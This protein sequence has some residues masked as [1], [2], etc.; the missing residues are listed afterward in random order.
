[1]K[2]LDLLTI[3]THTLLAF[4]LGLAGAGCL[5]T[6]FDLDVSLWPILLFCALLS[7]LPAVLL[8]LRW[9]LPI[10]LGLLAAGGLCL[11]RTNVVAQILSLLKV[12]F[13]CYRNAYGWQLPAFL[14]NAMPISVTLAVALIAGTCTLMIALFLQ[15]R[16]AFGCL[17]FAALPL[18][19]C[20]VVTDTVP[21]ASWLMLL[22]LGCILVLLSQKLRRRDPRQASRLVALA[23]IPTLVLSLILFRLN[24]EEDYRL[25]TEEGSF[26]NQLLQWLDEIPMIDVDENGEVN[27]DLS[28]MPTFP[29]PTFVVDVPGTVPLPTITIT[30]DPTFSIP[31]G[32]V[33]DI[34]GQ[35]PL[36][37]TGP[38]N[39]S[40]KQ[41]MQLTTPYVYR[42]TLYLRDRSYDMYTGTSWK[43]SGLPQDLSIVKGYLDASKSLTIQTKS[44]YPHYYAPYYTH[45]G[46]YSLPQGYLDNPNQLKLYS[47]AFYPLCADWQDLWYSNSNQPI[48]AIDRH[49]DQTALPDETYDKA[50]RILETLG[51]HNQ[52]SVLEAAELIRNYVSHSATY[53][54]NTA[55]MPEEYE[56]FALWFLEESDTGYCVHFATAATVLLRAAGIPARYVEGYM[57]NVSSFATIVRENQAHAWVEY[58]LPE[59]GWVIMEATP[60]GEGSP[61]PPDSTDPTEPTE[62]TETTEP[63]EPT[64]PTD[65]TDPTETT[66]P[67]EPTEPTE[68]TRPSETTHP[69]KPTAPSATT[70]VP[71]TTGTPVPPEPVDRTQLWATLAV[72]LGSLFVI[73]AIIAQW[74]LRL[75]LTQWYL[76]RGSHNRRAL[77]LWQYCR[78]MAKL[79]RQNAPM[80]LRDLA[81]KAAYSPYT[82]TEEELQMFYQYTNRC[83]AHLQSRPW[84][85]RL[86]YRLIFAAY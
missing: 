82:I 18:A 46:D 21:N 63:T 14:Q 16:Q 6:A 74:Q 8:Q 47:Y 24:P 36:G 49:W 5:C 72:V 28:E 51:I 10:L 80:A 11:S 76:S 40:N 44:S 50:S 65:P 67:T 41:V 29:L 66:E 2:K 60:A 23:L 33:E 22:L 68:S 84:F 20:L 38:R 78:R 81:W 45:T 42:G 70:T 37:N 52:M 25:P 15:M 69:T 4:L 17:L 71:A 35:V 79:R 48:S 39:P 73:C 13:T 61:V 32:L 53:D 58:Y 9:G 55:S 27:I 19:A 56:D 59:L 26:G 64:E 43:A 57:A 86:V 3:A 30:L 83:V 7:L 1:M 62:P 77:K 54:L 75:W 85:L 31:S 34:L 12:L